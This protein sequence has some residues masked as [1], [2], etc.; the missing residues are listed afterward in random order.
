MGLLIFYGIL[1]ACAMWATWRDD[2]L[3]WIGLWLAAGWALSNIVFATLPPVA[4]PGPFSFVEMMVALAAYLA[5]A[6]HK[7]RALIGIVALNVASISA[8]IAFAAINDPVWRQIHLYEVTVNLCFAAQCLVTFGV[9]VAHGR[10]T[11][12][13]HRW[14]LVRRGVAQ[15][16]AA[17]EAEQ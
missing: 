5:F 6:E 17:R 11:G 12:R 16:D 2:D 8:N 3:R 9:G 13:F 1:A 14:P 7:Y 10:R 4:R 15:P